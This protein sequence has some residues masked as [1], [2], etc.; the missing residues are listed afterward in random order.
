MSPV[1]GARVAVVD[2][3]APP[4][5]HPALTLARYLGAFPPAD[6]APALRALLREV[7]STLAGPTKRCGHCRRDLPREDFRVDRSQPA[8]LACYC[9]RCAVAYGRRWRAIRDGRGALLPPERQP[10]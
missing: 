2:R 6:R 10:A 9:R 3:M 5:G 8:G 4:I 7:Q 1:L